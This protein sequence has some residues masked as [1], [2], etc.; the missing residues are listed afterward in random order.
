MPTKIEYCDETWS[1]VTGCSPTS[2]GCQNCWAKRMSKRLAGRFGYPAAPHNFDVTLHPDKLDQPLHWKKPSMI[3]VNSMSDLF[4]EDV[5]DEFIYDCFTMMSLTP[6][7][8]FQILTKRPGR[9]LK[10]ITKCSKIE[11]NIHK[12][13][14]N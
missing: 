7:H 11:K 4:H 6:K 8:I 1:P 3:F 10:M 12:Y 5:S 9:A 14:Q 13:K 2:P